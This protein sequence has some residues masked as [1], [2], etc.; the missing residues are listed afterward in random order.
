MHFICIL[1][2]LIFLSAAT[3]I[4]HEYDTTSNPTTLKRIYDI[5]NRVYKHL[6]QTTFTQLSNVHFQFEI[7]IKR[8]QSLKTMSD[9]IYTDSKKKLSDTL[10]TVSTN[11]LFSQCAQLIDKNKLSM[12]VRYCLFS[13]SFLWF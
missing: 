4:A 8:L 9:I 2:A 13:K 10:K 6:Y 7:M 12:N 11:T 3:S 5:N 1:Y